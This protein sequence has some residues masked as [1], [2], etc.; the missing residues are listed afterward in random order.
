MGQALYIMNIDGSNQTRISDIPSSDSSPA[1]SPNGSWIAFDS[2]RSDGFEIYIMN[3]DGS[4]HARLTTNVVN[5]SNPAWR[6][7]YSVRH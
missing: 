3:S 7:N 4:D 5:D 1:W 2:W 6:P